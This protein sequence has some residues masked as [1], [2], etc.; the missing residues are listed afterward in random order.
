MRRIIFYLSVALLAFGIGSFVV[1]NLY[2]KRAEQSVIAKTTETNKLENKEQISTSIQQTSQDEEPDE[3]EKASFDVLK[4][5]I[6]K[7][8]R[9]EKIKKGWNDIT[10]ELIKEV[11]GQ[12]ESDLSEQEIRFWKDLGFQF[13]TYLMDADGDGKNE[14][15]IQNRCAPVGNCKFWLFRKSGNDYK[16]IL[17][18]LDGAVQTF[19]LRSSKT[20]G[21]FDFE[22][23]D[24]GSSSSGGID[25]YKFDGKK[26]K[27]SKCYDCNYSYLKD[28]KLYELK[29]PKITP[30][31][32]DE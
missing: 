3:E 6:K 16:A 14:L 24:H 18:T 20:N 26:Y 31:K 15:A 12:N 17:E 29:K 2:F 28:G 10:A 23:K 25:I 8:L 11:T 4:P 13:T 27:V 19:K 5:T 1:F 30:H 32:C 21:Y 7:W 22:T 9:G